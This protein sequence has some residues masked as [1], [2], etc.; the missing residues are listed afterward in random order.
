[1]SPE[2]FSS[3]TTQVLERGAQISEISHFLWV[4]LWL[5]MHKLSTS[6]DHFSRMVAQMNLIFGRLAPETMV[7]QLPPHVCH[8][9]V[10]LRAQGLLQVDI[11]AH[12]GIT[13]GEVSKILKRNAETGTPTPRPR[14]GRPQKITICDDCRLI[15]MSNAGRSKSAS[16]LRTEWQNHINVPVSVSLV[17]KRLDGAGYYAQR[18]L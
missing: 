14:P 5:K 6:S 9:V 15:R 13:Q 18:P 3:V 2:I 17:K 12:Y 4:E 7:F 1:M 10:A 8:G 16:T 11:A